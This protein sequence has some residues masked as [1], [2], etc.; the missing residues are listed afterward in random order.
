MQG[1]SQAIS[2]ASNLL[3]FRVCELG[4]RPPYD[5]TTLASDPRKA[6]SI[7]RILPF[8]VRSDKKQPFQLHSAYYLNFWV[9]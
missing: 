9:F 2:A 8:T 6:Q 5:A 4:H 1:C 3:V 7:L